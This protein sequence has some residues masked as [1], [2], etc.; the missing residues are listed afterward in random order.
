MNF[1]L[2][3]LVPA[4]VSAFHVMAAVAV[5]IDAV[6]RKRHVPS[7]IGWVGLAWLAP[8][9]GSVVYLCFG[10]NRIRRK[11][12]ALY[13]RGAW[14]RTTG[15]MTAPAGDASQGWV[16]A[17]VLAAQHSSMVGL[18][19]LG[20]EI[21]G[22]PLTAGNLV[23]PL[24]NGDQ[25]FPAM[26]EAIDGAQTSL[27]LAS[28]IF[29]N[30]ATGLLF[31]EAL[32]RA[33]DRGVAVRVLIDDVGARYSKPSMLR[34]LRKRGVPV[35]AFLPTRVPRLFQYANLRNHRKILVADGRCGFVGGTNIRHAHWLEKQPSYAARCLHFQL[36]G[37]VV[38]DLQRTFAMDWAFTTGELLQ[39]ETW[40][41]PLVQ[42]GPVIARGVRDGPDEDLDKILELVLGALSAATRQVRIVTPYFVIDSVLSRILQVTAMRGVD[43]QIVLP[44]RS[45]L[46]L[47][48]WAVAPQLPS[49]LA[50]GCRIYLSPPPFDHS[51]AML[52]DGLWS[53]IG[54]SNWDTRSLRLNFEYNVECYDGGLARVLNALIDE[55]IAEARQLTL[56]ET[57]S[58]SFQ[59]KLRNGLA[60]LLS[61]YL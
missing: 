7:V 19:R 8:V 47:I 9:V 45:N 1:E 4:L 38:E 46:P 40:F 17:D 31:L 15:A 11:A 23:Q 21:T 42:R 12:V 52:V 14:E 32:C 5:T 58:W 55:T 25:A 16:D 61:P 49:L 51:K 22:M 30:D 6:L 54:S 36:E 53:L 24:V 28:Y 60:R 57:Q 35:A 37:P 44:A 27:S 48:D 33:L 43:V 20:G 2:S 59:V 3:V 39:G 41:P 18:A 29:D 34:L 56:A 26:L 10:I 13:P 50:K